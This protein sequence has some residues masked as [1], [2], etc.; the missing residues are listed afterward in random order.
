MNRPRT[1]CVL[2]LE[3]VKSRRALAVSLARL[4]DLGVQFDLPEDANDLAFNES[5][6]LYVGTPFVGILYFQLAQV[7]EVASVRQAI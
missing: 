6:F 3:F 5:G 7:F 4:A 2:A 1:S